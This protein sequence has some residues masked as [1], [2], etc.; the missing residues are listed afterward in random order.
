[1]RWGLAGGCGRVGQGRQR[2]LKWDGQGPQPGQRCF[3]LL[4]QGPVLGR[5][6]DDQPAAARETGGPG[7][8][9]LAQR[10]SGTEAVDALPASSVGR[11]RFY[12]SA[13]SPSQTALAANCPDGRCASPQ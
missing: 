4:R 12:A 13:T 1:M 10:L 5:M 6:E 7:D 8:Q 2:S 3:D 9:P 11:P